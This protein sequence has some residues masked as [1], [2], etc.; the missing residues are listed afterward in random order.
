MSAELTTDR[1]PGGTL[2]A[3]RSLLRDLDGRPAVSLDE[4]LSA[5]ALSTRLDTKYL[6]RLDDL[7]AL[8]DRL[9]HRLA[10]L[11]IDGRRLFDYESV[12]FDTESLMLYRH[13]AQGRRKRYKV[14][15]RS[16]RNTN[17]A[18]LE[19]KLEGWRG[20]TVKERLPYDVHRR[21]ELTPEGHAFLD[22]VVAKAYGATVPPFG[23][24]LTTAYRRATLVDVQYESRLTIDVDLGWSDS[25]RAH[26]ADDL[27]LLESKNPS[28][29]GP[30]DALLGSLGI[31]PVRLSKYCLGVALLHPDIAA[32]PWSRL[33]RREFG[34]QRAGAASG[35]P[36]GGPDLRRPLGATGFE[37][38]TP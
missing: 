5:A 23:P 28:G 11:D 12:Y 4:V 10:A 33:L 1:S 36:E 9:P 21:K 34:W 7:P 37:P 24:I 35:T 14:R 17:D 27:A 30:V 38:A 18:M 15:T 2:P 26:Q 19:V 8:L 25:G 6:I 20:Q 16:Y 13:H 29:R 22:E 31:R 3:I 32:N